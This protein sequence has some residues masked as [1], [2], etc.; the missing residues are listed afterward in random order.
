MDYQR[1][2]DALM[3]RAKSREIK[4]Y[5][6]KHHILPRCLGGG[7]E[8]DNIARLTPEEHYVAHQ[9]LVKLNPGNPKL[10]YS[11]WV[12]A[13]GRE[14]SNKRYGWLRRLHSESISKHLTGYKRGPFSDEHKAK[15]TAAKKGRVMSEEQKK[16]ISASMKAHAGTDEAKAIVSATHSGRARSA[17]TKG[18]ISAANAGKVRL[19]VSCPHCDKVGGKSNMDRYHFDNCKVKNV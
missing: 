2:Y 19:K 9:L 8:V 17:E 7:D 14:G 13:A 18:K 1:H 16:K 15:L 6:E 3:S 12:M 4:G 10:V 11:A 5:V